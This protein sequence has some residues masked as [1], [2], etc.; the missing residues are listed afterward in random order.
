[1]EYIVEKVVSDYGYSVERADQ[2]NE[3]GS[4]TN[5]I[6]DK[7]VGSDLVIA[8]LTGHNPNVFYEL[9]VRHAAGQPFI[10][11]IESGEDIPFDIKDIRTV[12]YGLEVKEADQARKR[13][14]SHLESLENEQPEYDNPISRSAKM[15]SLRESQD[16]FDQNLAEILQNISELDRTVANLEKAMKSGP[17]I[18]SNILRGRNRYLEVFDKRYEIEGRI[19]AFN[20]IKQISEEVGMPPE[21]VESILIDSHIEIGN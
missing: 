16:P 4:I 20:A 6:I 7:T 13:I 19:I 3:P 5:Q 21:D 8:D 10:Q 12:R 17:E 1:M 18:E 9:A 15:K 2:T 11:L 14:R